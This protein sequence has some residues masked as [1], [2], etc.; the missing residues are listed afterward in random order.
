MIAWLSVSARGGR[1]TPQYLWKI[2]ATLGLG[3][4]FVA[5]LTLVVAPGKTG[6]LALPFNATSISFV[7]PVQ[8]WM[9]GFTPVSPGG[10]S[11]GAW[12]IEVARTTDGG[13]GWSG[14]VTVTTVP[15]TALR[16]VI[17]FADSLHGWV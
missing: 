1:K 7:S 17:R 15:D 14:V 8:G 12:N 6:V 11:Q 4:C 16:P 5:A 13:P 3:L 10:G 2:P 9:A